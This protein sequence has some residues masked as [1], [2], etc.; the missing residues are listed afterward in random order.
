MLTLGVLA[1]GR[2][3]NFQAIAENI[4]KGYLKDVSIRILIS[5]NQKAPV[6]QKA[7]DYGI[8]ALY[9]N[10]KEFANMDLYYRHLGD[11]LQKREVKIII[12]AGF[13][14]IVGKTLI[15]RF[16]N[17]IMNIHPA[18]LPSFP[19]LQGQKQ[20][21][22]YGVKITGCTVHFVD[23]G[24]DTGPIITQAAV[25]VLHNDT[26]ES[27]SEKILKE[28]HRIYSLAIKLY[29]E[30]NLIIEGRRVKIRNDKT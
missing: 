15:N 20:A 3:S 4:K 21:I 9:I 27:L 28:E 11:E 18:L 22:D 25:P 16:Q 8:E 30:G 5:D 10:P 14:R 23:E 2:G 29:S 12:L 13:M 1:S 24:I 26:E 6:L 17:Q 19:G 7:L